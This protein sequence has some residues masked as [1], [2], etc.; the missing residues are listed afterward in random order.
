MFSR[1]AV[2]CYRC[3]P[4]KNVEAALCVPARKHVFSHSIVFSCMYIHTYSTTADFKEDSCK[5]AQG[6][7]GL[8]E[9]VLSVSGV[10][11]PHKQKE[12]AVAEGWRQSWNVDGLDA[13]EIA[14]GMSFFFFGVI[15]DTALIRIFKQ[16][17]PEHSP[18][19]AENQQI[20]WICCPTPLPRQSENSELELVSCFSHPL[21]FLPAFLCQT[22]L[23]QPGESVKPTWR[24]NGYYLFILCYPHLDV[25]MSPF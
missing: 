19:V 3:G 6:F 16:Q 4:R 9:N 2:V 7:E 5:C 22:L 12:A 17:K 15:W 20:C 18:K 24:R 25:C 8:L 23:F 13:L 1:S 11:H 21:I 10:T 14:F